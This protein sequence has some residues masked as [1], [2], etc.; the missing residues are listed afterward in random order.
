M[1]PI[2][3]AK[4]NDPDN[5]HE[6]MCLI[7][8]DVSHMDGSLNMRNIS[9]KSIFSC[10]FSVGCSEIEGLSIAGYLKIHSDH[11]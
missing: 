2:S 3:T 1:I 9:S 8:I 5:Y 11:V 7:T 6:Y 10:F 4:I